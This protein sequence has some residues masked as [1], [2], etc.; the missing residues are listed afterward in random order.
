M[1]IFSLALMIFSAAKKIEL[2][3][4]VPA[5][6]ILPKQPYTKTDREAADRI[7]GERSDQT[8]VRSQ[9]RKWA[10]RKAIPVRKA[11]RK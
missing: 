11:R 10:R 8:A 1:E 2:F 7:Q 6:R 5:Y 9:C 4:T 3:R